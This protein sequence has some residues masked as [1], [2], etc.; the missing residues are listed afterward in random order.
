MHAAHTIHTTLVAQAKLIPK[1]SSGFKLV[2]PGYM[3]KPEQVFFR[4]GLNVAITCRQLRRILRNR[5]AAG[6]GSVKPNA[7]FIG[8]VVVHR[9]PVGPAGI[10]NPGCRSVMVSRTHNVVQAKRHHVVHH[11]LPRFHHHRGD[12]FDESG[13]VAERH[14]HPLLRDV[15]RGPAH[16]LGGDPGRLGRVRQPG[17]VCR[18]LEELLDGQRLEWRLVH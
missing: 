14:P 8:A 12:R 11:R 10:V 3:M 18:L 6:F 7:F 9:V 15:A 16:Q 2:I 13:V 4:A 1:C 17:R 5:V